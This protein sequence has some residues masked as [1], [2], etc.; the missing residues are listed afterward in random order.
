M[1]ARRKCP[2]SLPQQDRHPQAQNRIE[3]EVVGDAVD[4]R[5]LAGA[6]HLA[7]GRRTEGPGLYYAPTVLV[8]ADAALLDYRSPH[9]DPDL[10]QLHEGLAEK[11]LMKLKREDLVERIRGVFSQ[12][13]ELENCDLEDVAKELDIPPR[14]LRFE[15]AR[16][17]TSFSQIV[18]DF[19]FALARRLLTRTEESI[20][21]IVYLTGFSEPST[22]YR[23]FKRW[24][25]MT[26]VQ[27]REKHRVATPA[28]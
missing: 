25:G 6:E 20:D 14:R 5:G 13:L 3:D 27:Y 7:G 21:N 26:P 22:F 28:T 11:R 9:S 24:S 1:S 23:A 16:A 15:L 12:R 19:R 4:L 18:T 10:L 2:A 17:G 8:N